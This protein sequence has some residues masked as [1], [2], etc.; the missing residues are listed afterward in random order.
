[1]NNYGS[2]CHLSAIMSN[3]QQRLFGCFFFGF[4]FGFGL[5]VK[6]LRYSIFISV[7]SLFSGRGRR[8]LVGSPSASKNR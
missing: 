7:V 6:P 1:M 3:N 5:G 8:V 2:S 4:G